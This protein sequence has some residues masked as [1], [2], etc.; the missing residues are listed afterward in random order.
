MIPQDFNV[1]S[2]SSA[3]FSKDK[4]PFVEIENPYKTQ[5][6][7]DAF[8]NSERQQEQ[9]LQHFIK[10]QMGLESNQILPLT[11]L[12]KAEKILKKKH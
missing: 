9:D 12:I 5:V 3:F 7:Q 6:L 10:T 1:G 11:S 4:S 2:F 8:E